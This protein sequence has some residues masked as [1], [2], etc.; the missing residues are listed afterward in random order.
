MLA[1]DIPSG[2]DG[3][4]GS[5][6]AG[7]PAD[8][9]VTFA[10]AKPGLYLG[11]GRDLAGDV[12]VVDIGLDVSSA[13]AYVVE[14]SDVAQWIGRRDGNAHKWAQAVRVVAGSPA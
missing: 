4:T 10:A 6:D 9:T 11:N 7:T 5:A 1:V 13:T 12:R 8:V 3:N 2:V 14:A